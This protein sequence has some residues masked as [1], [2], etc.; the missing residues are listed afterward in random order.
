[1]TISVFIYFHNLANYYLLMILH[2]V[3]DNILSIQ[4]TKLKDNY[5]IRE[6]SLTMLFIF[7]MNNL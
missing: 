4:T 2:L 5:S 3:P 1:L 6:M 7:I